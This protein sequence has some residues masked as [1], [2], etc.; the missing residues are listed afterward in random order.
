M[1]IGFM[2]ALSVCL[3]IL[4]K[5]G[6]VFFKRLVEDKKKEVEYERDYKIRTLKALESLSEGL[7][8]EEVDEKRS[9]LDN[10]LEG[11]KKLEEKRRL[12]QAMKDELG[13]E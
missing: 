10:L 5:K 13:I 3:I 8:P 2:L 1:F 7:R 11:N 9:L 6:E 12:R 4:G